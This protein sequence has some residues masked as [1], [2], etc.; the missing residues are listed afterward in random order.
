MAFDWPDA[1]TL[2]T[3]PIPDKVLAA[4]GAD[5]SATAEGVENVLQL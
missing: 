3:M 2:A 5:R 4:G 1:A